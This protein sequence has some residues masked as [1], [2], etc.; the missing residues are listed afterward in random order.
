MEVDEFTNVRKSTKRERVG[1]IERVR[2]SR[3]RETAEG[4]EERERIHVVCLE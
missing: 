1:E 2:V 4:R 3:K